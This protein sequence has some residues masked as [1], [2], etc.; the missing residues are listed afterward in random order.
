M[1]SQC[2]SIF[3]GGA[4]PLGTITARG[5][6][7]S[8]R[9]NA[10][11]RHPNPNSQSY[12]IVWQDSTPGATGVGAGQKLM[13]QLVD[14]ASGTLRWQSPAVICANSTGDQ[15]QC[16]A[17][18]DETV[19]CWLCG[20]M[21]DMRNPRRTAKA[22][23]R[24]ISIQTEATV[25][26]PQGIEVSGKNR[27]PMHRLTANVGGPN[28][29]IAIAAW[30]AFD[31]SSKTTDTDIFTQA[32]DSSGNLIWN[33]GNPVT[34]CNASNNKT[35]PV[36]FQ[37]IFPAQSSRGATCAM[38]HKSRS[39]PNAST[40]TASAHR[41]GRQTAISCESVGRCSSDN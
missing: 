35:S 37:R 27:V 16:S 31:P 2:T 8:K 18:P 20:L 9:A 38:R 11:T 3:N 26:F 23:S 25:E 39:T 19:G 12:Y 29:G 22:C 1:E 24:R 33:L 10:S 28:A 5:F 7:R 13:A 32:I 34:V 15:T 40:S 21:H 17:V 4:T 41:C 6:I 14:G 36:M 30:Q